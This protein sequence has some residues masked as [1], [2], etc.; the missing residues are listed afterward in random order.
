M[1]YYKIR[2]ERK[3]EIMGKVDFAATT[4]IVIFFNWTE[5]RK[6]LLY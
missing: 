1:E 6:P 5:P 2:K 4:S 3:S